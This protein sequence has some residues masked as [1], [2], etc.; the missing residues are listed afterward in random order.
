MSNEK[1]ASEIADQTHELGDG[2]PES[3]HVC[4]LYKKALSLLDRVAEDVE[5]DA[6]LQDNTAEWERVVRE[7]RKWAEGGVPGTSACDEIL[8]RMGVKK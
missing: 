2:C 4:P 5:L 1:L 8:E 7:V 6:A 3:G